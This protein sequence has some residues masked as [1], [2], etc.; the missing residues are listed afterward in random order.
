[1]TSQSA[2]QVLARHTVPKLTAMFFHS[3][4]V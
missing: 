3:S 4:S 1:M 2:R